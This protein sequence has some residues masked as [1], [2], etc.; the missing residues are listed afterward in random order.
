MDN[1]D[2]DRHKQQARNLALQGDVE[3]KRQTSRLANTINQRKCRER[4][5]RQE[6]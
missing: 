6:P 2:R 1:R 4:Q 3:L 5:E